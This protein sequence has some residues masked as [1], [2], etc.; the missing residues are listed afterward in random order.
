MGLTDI[1]KSG[2]AILIAGSAERPTYMSFGIGSGATGS[3]NTVLITE[4]GTRKIF[5][6]TDI[7]TQKQ[8]NFT[9][10]WGSNEMSGCAVTETGVFTI[11][12]GGKLWSRDG[13]SAVNLDGN[14]ELQVQVKYKIF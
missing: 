10:S 4:S 8:I 9:A 6:S 7:T 5:S 1:G 2:L 3:T 13:F 14:T 11:S 12:S